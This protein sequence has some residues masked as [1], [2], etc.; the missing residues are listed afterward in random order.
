MSWKAEQ[1]LW[2]SWADE[3]IVYNVSSGNTHTISP[4]AAKVLRRLEDSPHTTH[5]IAQYLTSES[6]LDLDD[7]LIA[8]VERVIEDLD[9]LGLV[10]PIS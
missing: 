3:N 4:I 2:R 6:D 7:E 1:L 8:H 5:Q 10:L 9:E